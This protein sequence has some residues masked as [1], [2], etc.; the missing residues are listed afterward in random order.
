MKKKISK[1][2]MEVIAYNAIV[3]L[4]EALGNDENPKIVH[5]LVINDLA[6]SEREYKK[7]MGE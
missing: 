2:R 6:I 5:E 3:R 7:I 1:D 4:E